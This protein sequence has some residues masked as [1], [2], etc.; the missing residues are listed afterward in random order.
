MKL[1][2]NIIAID[3]DVDK[4]GIAILHRETKEIQLKSL[5]FAETIDFVVD[6]VMSN[7][8]TSV[9]IEAGWK[10]KAHWH[11]MP[12]DTKQSAAAKGNATGRNHETGRKLCEML[13]HR[14]IAYQLVKPLKKIWNTKDGKISHEELVKLTGLKDKRSNQEERDAALIAWVCGKVQSNKA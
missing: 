11:L 5:N 6:F 1:I 2:D 4:N 3:P 13:A 10:N 14:G 7:I 9:Y 8:Q 12:Y